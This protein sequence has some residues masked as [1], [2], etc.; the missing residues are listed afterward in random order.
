MPASMKGAPKVASLNINSMKDTAV[1]WIYH[2][3]LAPRTGKGTRYRHERKAFS[4]A[5]LLNRSPFSVRSVRKVRSPAFRRTPTGRRR[6]RKST[7]RDDAAEALPPPL[8]LSQ[9]PLSMSDSFH[10][11]IEAAANGGAPDSGRRGSLLPPKTPA[12]PMSA[13]NIEPVSVS[14]NPSSAK[15]PAPAPRKQRRRRMSDVSGTNLP[16]GNNRPA[17]AP[18]CFPHT[19]A[20]PKPAGEAGLSTWLQEAG[21]EKVYGLLDCLLFWRDGALSSLPKLR[22]AENSEVLEAIAPIKLK[23]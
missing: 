21:L 9:V 13:R 2:A 1:D 20:P 10:A 3:P 18:A 22:D 6:S 19:P 8:E 4:P 17:P 11:V 12:P 14:N 7:E 5:A 16:D 15:T 23:G